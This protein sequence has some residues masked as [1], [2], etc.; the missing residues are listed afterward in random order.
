MTKAEAIAI[1]ALLP[2]ARRDVQEVQ[3]RLTMHNEGKL[4]LNAE[5]IENSAK[6]L[7]R[8]V[9]A[10]DTVTKMAHASLD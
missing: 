9:E 5:S 6:R 2:D 8:S 10:I 4:D 1:N 3:L 7:A